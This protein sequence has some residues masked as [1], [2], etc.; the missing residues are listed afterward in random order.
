MTHWPGAAFHVIRANW[1]YSQFAMLLE[2]LNERLEREAR[3]LEDAREAGRNG[4]AMSTGRGKSQ[5]LSF[6]LDDLPAGLTPSKY[7]NLKSQKSGE[8]RGNDGG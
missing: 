1:T 3:A 5:K 6:T 4:G 7:P 8:Q 2:R